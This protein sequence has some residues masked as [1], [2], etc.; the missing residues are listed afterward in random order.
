MQ[1]PQIEETEEV[2]ETEVPDEA[3][4][5]EVE[6]AEVPDMRTIH[7]CQRAICTGNLARKV[8]HVLTDTTAPGEISRAQDQETTETFQPLLPRLLIERLTNLTNMF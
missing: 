4:P 8:G 3:E 1:Q 5:E 7:H 6:G 2:E